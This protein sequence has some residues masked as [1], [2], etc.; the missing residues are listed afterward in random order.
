MDQLLLCWVELC[1]LLQEEH[2]L[3]S[4]SEDRVDVVFPPQVLSGGRPQEY[5][6]FHSGHRAGGHDGRDSVG[7]KKC[8]LMLTAS[9]TDKL[10]LQG[11]YS[12]GL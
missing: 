3:L 7:V 8:T 6:G 9:S 1:Q 10:I 2:L 4:L 11:V 5:E 12:H